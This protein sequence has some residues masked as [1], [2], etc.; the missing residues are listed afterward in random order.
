[1][2]AE[3][4]PK[5]KKEGAGKGLNGN[6]NL[7]KDVEAE[8]EGIV[9]EMVV[10]M[11][12]H[13]NHHYQRG[14]E[15]FDNELALK[16]VVFDNNL[17]ACK[18]ISQ[19]KNLAINEKQDALL[20]DVE[21]YYKSLDDSNGSDKKFKAEIRPVLERESSSFT[22]VSLN[23]MIEVEKRMIKHAQHKINLYQWHLNEKDKV[24]KAWEII[25][26][27]CDVRLSANHKRKRPMQI[28]SQASQDMDF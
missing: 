24:V 16:N 13:E 23:E 7:K 2:S 1:M 3:E 15:V 12:H 8:L 25:E 18:D 28:R 9:T 4:K 11:S 26:S 14:S 21:D 22:V 5:P 27:E 10:H 19:K 6:T 20:N 17:N